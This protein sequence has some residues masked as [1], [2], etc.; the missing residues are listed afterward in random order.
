MA[1]RLLGQIHYTRLIIYESALASTTTSPS[2]FSLSLGTTLQRYEFLETCL[3]AIKDWFNVYFLLPIDEYVGVTYIFWG[4]MTHCIMSLYLLM[5]IN[6]DPAWDRHRLIVEGVDPIGVFDRFIRNF[7]EYATLRELEA[8]PESAVHNV[9]AWWCRVL[10]L[11][12][13][14][15]KSEFGGASED[16]PAVLGSNNEAT[17]NIASHLPQL[18]LG[19]P[20][21]EYMDPVAWFG[22]CLAM[23]W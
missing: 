18:Q 14:R 4:H 23:D 16:G 20:P 8:G 10:R 21:L 13:E 15:W 7:D 22:E 17:V 12:K 1:E 19:T 5:Q 6:D 2:S 11:I 3:G 9:F